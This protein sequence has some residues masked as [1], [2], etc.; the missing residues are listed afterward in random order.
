[1]EETRLMRKGQ[2]VLGQLVAF[3]ATARLGSFRAAADELHIT[4]GAVAQQVR[5]MEQKLGVDLFERL[6]RGTR[7]WPEAQGFLSKVQLALDLVNDATRELTARRSGTR[8]L[9]LSTTGAFASRW[10]IPKLA[11][12]SEAE[13]ALAVMVD[14]SNAA[15]SLHGN[16]AVDMAIRWGTPPFPGCHVYPLF[17]G[18]IIPV[19]APGVKRQYRWQTLNDLTEDAPLIADSHENWSK[20]FAARGVTSSST[21]QRFSQTSLAIEAAERGL[22]IALAPEVLVTGALAGGGLV[23]ALDEDEV[24]DTDAGFYLLTAREPDADSDLGKVVE[25]LL[26]NSERAAPG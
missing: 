10:L 11:H 24:M 6:P 15:R 20:W 25:W 9:T 23:R 22:G 14:A 19:C 8:T 21:V 7:L 18:S 3:E 12:L 16:D 26:G 1:M 17:L 13:P 4:T 2:T 5:L